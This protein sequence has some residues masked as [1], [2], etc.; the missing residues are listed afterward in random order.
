MPRPKRPKPIHTVPTKLR[1]AES[2]I[3]SKAQKQRQGLAPQD[4]ESFTNGSDD[5]DGLVRRNRNES[6]VI[7]GDSQVYMMS[8][9]LGQ[10]AVEAP[11]LRPPTEKTMAELPKSTSQ[12]DLAKSTDE[13]HSRHGKVQ[14]AQVTGSNEIPSSQPYNPPFIDRLSPDK[15]NESAAN[16]NTR[17]STGLRIQGTPLVQPSMLGPAQF[18]KRARQPSLLQLAQAH[19]EGTE[20]F[21]DEDLYDFR[22]DDESTPLVKSLLQSRHRPTTSSLP[23]MGSRKRKLSTPEIQVPA[24]QSQGQRSSTPSDSSH[25][26]EDE[27][28]CDLSPHEDN[29]RPEPTLPRLRQTRTPSPQIFSDTLAP[30]QSSSSPAKAS[31]RAAR[32]KRRKLATTAK[33]AVHNQRNQTSP[34]PSSHSNTPI[35][36]LSSA[37]KQRPPPKPLTTASLQNLLPR[38][39]RR[40]KLQSTYDVPSSSDVEL[41]IT[42]L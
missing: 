40:P 8:G 38:R 4:F 32:F 11:R 24:S 17:L 21:D 23:S 7:V 13:R 18:K 2:T 12:A 36:H 15:P 5:S 25:S 16:L 14:S 19:K 35:S 29:G 31:P 26:L 3:V 30:P 10:D 41:D 33:D 9:A 37:P 27:G 6:N 20:A 39:R 34:A 42:H 1:V 22:P 28:T